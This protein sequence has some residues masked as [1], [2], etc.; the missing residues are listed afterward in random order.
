[1]RI[2]AP[3]MVFKSEAIV[4]P[5]FVVQYISPEECQISYNPTL[6]NLLWETLA[7][8][9][10]RLLH[11]SMVKRFSI[12]SR[13]AWVNYVRCHDDIGWS[14]ANEDA[15]ELGLNGFDHRQFLNRFFTGQFEGSFAT[16][17]PFNYNPRTLDMRISGMAASLAGLEQAIESSD[18][19]YQEHAIRRIILIHSIILSIGGIPLLYLGD[20]LGMTND[21]SYR[22]NPAVADDSRWVHRPRFDWQLASQRTDPST[23][24]GRIFQTLRHLIQVRKGHPEFMDADTVFV[25]TG[26]PHVLGYVRHG[27]LLILANFSEYAQSVAVDAV[28]ADWAGSGSTLDLVTGDSFCCENVITLE[29]YQVVWLM[30]GLGGRR[31]S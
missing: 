25:P 6:M 30:S 3:A 17:L 5:D 14:F 2:V 10:V 19:L 27:R 20:E 21:Y 28:A 22:Q 1:V 8:R 29:P 23:T 18:V 12:D 26:N 9:E 31:M 13:C 24:A 11:H 4:H 15:I 7:T 16:G